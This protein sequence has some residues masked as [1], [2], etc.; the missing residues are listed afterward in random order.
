MLS[1][2]SAIY[3]YVNPFKQDVDTDC[4]VSVSRNSRSRRQ[5]K[6]NLMYSEIRGKLIYSADLLCL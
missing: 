5:S 4:A 1:V 6:K 2:V 3:L